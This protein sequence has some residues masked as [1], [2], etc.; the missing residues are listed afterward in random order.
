MV[1]LSIIGI[2][3][4]TINTSSGPYCPFP[5]YKEYYKQQKTQNNIQIIEFH[6]R[7]KV[8][9]CI[10]TAMLVILTFEENQDLFPKVLQIQATSVM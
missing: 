2:V 6:S 10:Y 3:E 7:K 9:L 1:E 5:Y 8:N 4:E